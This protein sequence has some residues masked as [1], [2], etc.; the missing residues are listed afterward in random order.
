MPI[1]PV[2]PGKTLADLMLEVAI[3]FGLA[4]VVDNDGNDTAPTLPTEAS[5]LGVLS[6]AVNAGYEDFLRANPNWSFLDVVLD[7]TMSPDGTDTNCVNGDPGRYILPLGITS[8][9]IGFWNISNTDGAVADQ[10]WKIED[11]ASSRVAR[12]WGVMTE[13]NLPR[14][15]A[16]RPLPQD[17]GTQRWEAIF[18]PKPDKA[19]PVSAQFR[20]H[21]PR[22]VDQTDR[23]MAGP[24]HDRT[25][26][27]MAE[28]HMARGDMDAGPSQATAQ[29]AASQALAQS[30]ELDGEMHPTTF[31]VM[32]EVGN[33][34]DSPMTRADVR[35]LGFQPATYNGAP[36][37]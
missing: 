2:T 31:G 26:R 32:P 11:T 12:W 1:S 10:D 29:A 19:Y 34:D 9:P 4:R 24:Q 22:L 18:A 23:H 8:R 3:T 5:R 6:D 30:I 33:I 14:I 17:D 36:L 25:L 16:V 35:R 27:L 28:A 37:S 15:A 13:A 21:P 20:L 7:L